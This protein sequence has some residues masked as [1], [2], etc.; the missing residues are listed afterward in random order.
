LKDVDSMKQERMKQHKREERRRRNL[1]R[2]ERSIY[3]VSRTLS[4]TCSAYLQTGT[5]DH[6]A[7]LKV[8]QIPLSSMFTTPPLL[9]Q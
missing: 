8:C 7:R 6:L 5:S 2:K 1:S 3:R 9:G 4:L